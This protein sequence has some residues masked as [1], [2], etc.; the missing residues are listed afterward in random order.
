[1]SCSAYESNGSLIVSL[2]ERLDSRNAMEVRERCIG[3]IADSDGD[4]VFDLERLD[5]IDAA[6][7]EVLLVAY[8]SLDMMGRHLSILNAHGQPKAA[9]DALR[10]TYTMTCNTDLAG[11]DENLRISA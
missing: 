10:R 6:G 8:R 9:L 1:M 11:S 3:F 4:V 5:H 7:L 2:F